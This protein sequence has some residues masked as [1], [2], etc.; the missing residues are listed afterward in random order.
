MLLI[1]FLIA[2]PLLLAIAA[3]EWPTPAGWLGPTPTPTDLWAGLGL[4]VLLPAVALL[5]WQSCLP[6]RPFRGVPHPTWTNFNH[7]HLPLVAWSVA[8]L[9]LTWVWGWSHWVTRT[10]DDHGLW[11]TTLIL[12]PHLFGLQW[13]WTSPALPRLWHA[14]GASERP[15]WRL[16]QQLGA[17]LLSRLQWY[18][19]PVLLPLIVVVAGRE[20]LESMAFWGQL[21]GLSQ[22]ITLTVG[23]MTVVW[24]AFPLVLR[25]LL[26]TRPLDDITLRDWIQ[27]TSRSLRLGCREIACWETQ[28]R[29]ANAMVLGG[30]PGCRQILISDLLCGVLTRSE[31]YAVFLHEAGHLRRRHLGWRMVTLALATQPLLLSLQQAH[32][33]GAPLAHDSLAGLAQGLLAFFCWFAVS[34]LLLGYVSRALEFDADAFAVEHALHHPRQ[35]AVPCPPPQASQRTNPTDS[36]LAPSPPAA[37]HPTPQSGECQIQA[38]DLI[39]AL[40]KT[41]ILTRTRTDQVSW[42]HPSVE[43]RIARIRHLQTS[44]AFQRVA[45]RRLRLIKALL[46]LGLFLSLLA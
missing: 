10:T 29:I 35:A 7:V 14:S 9:S 41:A 27:Q 2:I 36:P 39:S 15:V 34:L 18:L 46:V 28:Q 44:A 12:L 4:H 17:D 24:L 38:D 25:C 1:Q 37:H 32:V 19:L 13:V 5:A 22:V 45:N 40:Q 11:G 6:S 42:L 33:D 20:C 8:S 26:P 3:A 21:D 16:W 30:L 31:L 43:Q 23:S